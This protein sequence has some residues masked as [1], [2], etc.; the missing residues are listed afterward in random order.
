MAL[1]ESYPFFTLFFNNNSNITN[2]IDGSYLENEF[3]QQILGTTD[4]SYN[5]KLQI[6]FQCSKAIKKLNICV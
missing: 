6:H 3:T 4:E 2:E 1:V 5:L